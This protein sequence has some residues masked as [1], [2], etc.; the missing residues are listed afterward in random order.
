MVK[1][2]YPNM[3]SVAVSGRDI[4][5]AKFFAEDHRTSLSL[6]DLRS[7]RNVVIK[8]IDRQLKGH[9]RKNYLQNRKLSLLAREDQL[10]EDLEIQRQKEKLETTQERQYWCRLNMT[11][12][13]T[14]ATCG[15]QIVGCYAPNGDHCT[16]TP[17]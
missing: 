2:L 13:A 12:F 16:L 3:Q 4:P 1:T 8:L 5:I 17:E 10:E 9:P 14:M 11:Y 6:E 15:K 7:R